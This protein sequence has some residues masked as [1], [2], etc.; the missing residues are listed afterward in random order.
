MGIVLWL[1]LAYESVDW[2]T[3]TFPG[4]SIWI[5]WSVFALANLP[6]MYLFFH[7]FWKY[8]V[9]VAAL[10]LVV[11]EVY[12]TGNC[13]DVLAYAMRVTSRPVDYSLILTFLFGIVF[14]P[15]ALALIPIVC[16]TTNPAGYWWGIAAAIS[17]IFIGLLLVSTL[18]IFFSLVFQVF[19]FSPGSAG[20]S[21][22]RSMDLVAQNVLKTIIVI[23]VSVTVTQL[24]FPTLITW[25]VEMTGLLTVIEFPLHEMIIYALQQTQKDIAVFQSQ[26]PILFQFYQLLASKPQLLTH[27]AAKTIV[28]TFVS[29]FL[30]PLGTA[31]FALLYGDLKTRLESRD[32]TPDVSKSLISKV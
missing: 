31:W 20:A 25:G 29:A 14:V 19:A 21:L 1:V 7:G 24:I 6:G 2:M 23:L 13:P 11:R 10:N 22:F 32:S 16:L 18:L 4:V 8:L 30:L 27:E 28:Y 15:F 5:T 3:L 26:S 9:W 12:E 17:I